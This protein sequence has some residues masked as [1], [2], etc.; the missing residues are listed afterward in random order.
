MIE[1]T[2]AYLEPGSLPRL[3]LRKR[4]Q[5]NIQ[6][7]VFSG[8]WN[9]GRVDLELV[10]WL[11]ILAKEISVINQR[12]IKRQST[13]IVDFLYP[14][15]T[16]K[17]FKNITCFSTSRLDS[18]SRNAWSRKLSYSH[19]TPSVEASKLRDG[20][21]ECSLELKDLRQELTSL[22]NKFGLDGNFDVEKAWK[23]YGNLDEDNRKKI[24]YTLFLYLHKS[25]RMVDVKKIIELFNHMDLQEK[26]ELVY[27]H[28]A[29]AYLQQN[30]L[31]NSMQV[32]SSAIQNLKVSAGCDYI[33]DYLVD[34]ERWPEAFSFWKIEPSLKQ[35][36][37][38]YRFIDKGYTRLQSALSLASWVN[39]TKI[40]PETSP[41]PDHVKFA[42]AIVGKAF[43]RAK[44]GMEKQILRI[45]KNY[46]LAPS[47][48]ISV[49]RLFCSQHDVLGMKQVLDDFFLLYCKPS[50]TAYRMCLQEFARQGD[51]RTVHGLFK[52]YICRYRNNNHET[53][54][55]ARCEVSSR[56]KL[57]KSGRSYFYEEIDEAA[58]L[59]ANDFAPLLH[60]H[61][62]RGESFEVEKS[63]DQMKTL[64]FIKPNILCWNIRLSSYIKNQDTDKAYVCFEEILS[65]NTLKP[66]H[67]TLGTMMS[68][69]AS[70][71]D[72]VRTRDI[73]KLAENLEIPLSA[74]MLNCLVIC[75]LRN[76]KFDEAEAICLD[77]TARDIIGSKT[78]M[79]NSLVIAYALNCDLENVNRIFTIMSEKKVEYDKYTYSALMQALVMRRQP[80]LAAKIL[81]EIMPK[82]QVKPTSF[83]YAVL[84]GGYLAIRDWKMFHWVHQQMVKSKI[85]RSVS[86]QLMI[87]RAANAED[88]A[89]FKE[90]TVK[91]KIM[92]SFNIFSE[93]MASIDLQD[94][95]ET[96]RK[97]VSQVP[98][99]IM[100]PAMFYGFITFILGQYGEYKVA[101]DLLDEYK[102]QIPEHRRKAGETIKI[103]T[104]MMSAK[105]ASQD[106]KGVI[107]CWAKALSLVLEESKPLPPLA[108]IKLSETASDCSIPHFHQLRINE[109]FRIYMKTMVDEKNVGQLSQ[110]VQ[111]ITAIGFG[112]DS[113][114]WNEYVKILARN[115]NYYKLAFQICEAKLMPGWQEWRIQRRK[116][117]GRRMNVPLVVRR[118]KC[119]PR[120]LRPYYDTMMWLT[121]RMIDLQARAAEDPEVQKLINFLIHE[122]PKTIMAIEKIPRTNSDDESILKLNLSQFET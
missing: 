35:D 57:D 47:A 73:C 104:A 70:R 66:D 107:D 7:R 40:S 16:L 103:L 24:R 8:L 42:L 45:N 81:F 14:A 89:V 114:N 56:S 23:L 98:L 59:T 76:D 80:S 2:T 115:S 118:A 121:R 13:T 25:T 54:S 32:Y 69:F 92:R 17:C 63:F 87:M 37:N 28:A 10:P 102:T 120:S 97:G 9:Y 117:A 93:T 106:F 48:L 18:R 112:L 43:V 3:L 26:D 95:T 111:T 44:P 34:N 85:K 116:L 96:A 22:C 53:L 110:T 99:D 82:A 41:S 74:A 71:A 27:R 60:V 122:C 83:S 33:L 1:R 65:D 100:Y 19:S 86:T 109:P 75:L 6:S 21:S 72:L 38:F 55:R 36:F 64:F 29:R 52:Q 12:S 30:D 67:Y 90:G 49:L 11:A 108:K 50:R 51:A 5:L 79:W 84:L 105:Y 78:N 39:S 68:L 58:P 101:L 61:A 113:R 46:S 4:K 15:A 62:K 88:A 91:Q 119:N 31:T 77:S 94:I 20:Y